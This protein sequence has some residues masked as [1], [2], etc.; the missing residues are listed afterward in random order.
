MPGYA[1]GDRHRLFGTN[2]GIHLRG[3]DIA[4][5]V[6]LLKQTERQE[7]SCELSWVLSQQQSILDP[8]LR[9]LQG[10]LGSNLDKPGQNP[11]QRS[12]PVHLCL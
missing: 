8:F 6:A 7:A 10:K 1:V 3:K 5:K 12:S 4:G 9:A 2:I 11:G